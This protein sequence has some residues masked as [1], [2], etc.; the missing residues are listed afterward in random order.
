VA[1][2][3]GNAQ[4]LFGNRLPLATTSGVL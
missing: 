3:E 2:F 1:I 4:R